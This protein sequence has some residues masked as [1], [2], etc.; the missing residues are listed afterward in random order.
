MKCPLPKV[1]CCRLV[2][3][4][5]TNQDIILSEAKWVIRRQMCDPIYVRYLKYPQFRDSRFQG[6]NKKELGVSVCTNFQFYKIQRMMRMNAGH[7]C[8]PLWVFL[9]Q[10]NW[11][12]KMI[13]HNLKAQK[14]KTQNSLVLVP[15][16]SELACLEVPSI[17]PKKS[18]LFDLK[19]NKPT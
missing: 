17:R 16:L 3:S 7:A 15:L 4:W 10:L 6:R 14:E 18:I 11:G 2:T 9:I 19:K 13:L 1:V 12:L 5:W 8:A